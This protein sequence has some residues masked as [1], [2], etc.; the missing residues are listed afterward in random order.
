MN[1]VDECRE[2]L[3]AKLAP[4]EAEDLQLRTRQ[5]EVRAAIDQIH[6]SIAALDEPPKSLQRKTK[7][8]AKA[9]DP[10]VKYVRKPDVEAACSA[11]LNDN[12]NIEGFILKELAEDKLV[13]DLK[14]DRKGVGLG[15]E[16][17]MNAHGLSESPC[18]SEVRDTPSVSLA[19]R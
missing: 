8:K 7:A 18:R 9:S 5:D 16:R 1:I 11:I 19:Q 15:I 14:F 6:L 13:N 3:L 12:P 17:W 10:N 2:Y 4:L